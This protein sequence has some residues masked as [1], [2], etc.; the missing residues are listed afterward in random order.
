MTSTRKETNSLVNR[1]KADGQDF[2]FYP[3]T[4]EML[5][6]V[7]KD[8][9]GNCA[10]RTW[11]QNFNVLDVGAGDCRLGKILNDPNNEIIKSLTDGDFSLGKMYITYFFFSTYL[12]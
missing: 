9:Y 3:T 11:Q 2:E 12:V 6:V 8:F 1:L 4:Q 10:S 7:I 5:D